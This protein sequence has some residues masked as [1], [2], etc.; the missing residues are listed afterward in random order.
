MAKIGVLTTKI[1]KKLAIFFL[2][3][4]ILNNFC[5]T[6]EAFPSEYKPGVKVGE[7]IEYN[8]QINASNSNQYP[9]RVRREILE[10][11]GTTLKVNITLW[12]P[13]G[14]SKSEIREGDVVNDPIN[15]SCSVYF[16]PANLSV[17]DRVH[18]EFAEGG[19][20]RISREEERIYLNC[21]RKV[22]YAS[23]IGRGLNGSVYWDKIKGVALELNL[24]IGKLSSF[25]LVRA[26]NMFSSETATN[27]SFLYLILYLVTFLVVVVAGSLYYLISEKKRTSRRRKLGLK[28]RR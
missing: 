8:Q 21:S 6:T 7:W 19:F 14:S 23:F 10:V 2:L 25:L 15:G 26:T 1:F 20:I 9:S 5:L 13:D 18:R 27:G 17:G 28:R 22:L 4:I 12:Y 3:A 24:T 16:I 11:N